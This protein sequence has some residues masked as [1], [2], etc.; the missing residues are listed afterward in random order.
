MPIVDGEIDSS[1]SSIPSLNPILS[2][3]LGLMYPPRGG[4]TL[5]RALVARNVAGGNYGALYSSNVTLD[6]TAV[7]DNV[8]GGVAGAIYGS[9]I[10]LK[11]VTVAGNKAVDGGGVYVAKKA[12]IDNSILASNEAKAVTIEP[13]EEGAEA[14]TVGGDGYDLYVKSGASLAIRNSLV[15]NVDSV[16]EVKFA[17]KWLRAENRSF[18]GTDP[19][20]ADPANGDYSL[21]ANSPA[22]ALGFVPFDPAQAGRRTHPA[23]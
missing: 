17:N 6:N 8:A 2:M 7:V 21:K 3:S 1:N 4:L 5:S 13:T 19:L 11:N 22:L 16:G 14:T 20:F 10:K 18:I 9:S 15:Q 23:K 12:T